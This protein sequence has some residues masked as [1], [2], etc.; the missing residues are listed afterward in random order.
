[1]NNKFNLLNLDINQLEKIAVDIKLKPFQA[2]QIYKWL[3]EKMIRQID[4]I[5]N[6]SKESRTL[7]SEIAYI[8]YIE[9]KKREISKIDRTEKFLF[10][11]NDKNTIE[12]V[13]L[14]HKDR[15]TICVSTQAGCPVKCAFCA[16]GQG[17]FHRN[18]D[19]SEILNQVYIV[20]RRLSKE[21]TNITNIVFMGMGEPLLNIDTL[22]ES[23]N[24]FSSEDG[25]NISKRKITISTCGIIPGIERLLEN[26]LPV[27][28]AISLHAA[29]D[30]K[31]NGII[32]INKTY[33]ID[34]LLFS[35]KNYQRLTKRR[36]SFEYI[37]IDDFNLFPED[38]NNLRT[39]LKDYDHVL[40]LIPY[41]EVEG[42]PFKRPPENKINNFFNSLKR[43]GINVT[44]RR[45]KGS[46]ISGA[47]GQL[48][49]KNRSE[50]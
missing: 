44:L 16:T 22:I 17:T 11:L 32:P 2:K 49:E 27:E 5:T 1:M 14:R 38:V 24:T 7:L 50:S 47:C 30:F 12:T 9:L 28:L 46:D 43:Y 8:P 45:E 25:I 3:H 36:I 18:L 40:N 31:R 23:I 20:N 37:L 39:I 29:D 35:L 41:N 26:H 4:E 19:L 10:E 21:N 48:K 15:N 6:I 34:D 13:L 42:V 33:P